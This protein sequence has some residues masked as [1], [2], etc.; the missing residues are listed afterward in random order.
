MVMTLEEH[1]LQD[2]LDGTIPDGSLPIVDQAGN[3]AIRYFRRTRIMVSCRSSQYVFVTKANIC[4]A[5]IPEKHA[6][7]ILNKRGGCCG[8]Q[9]PGVFKYANSAAVRQW[10]N[11]GGR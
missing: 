11:G 5:W 3:V 8:Q 4:M 9:R 10:T 2:A 6:Q 7:C 1:S